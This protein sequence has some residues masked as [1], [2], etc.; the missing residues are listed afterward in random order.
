M[1]CL[2]AYSVSAYRQLAIQQETVRQKQ[3]KLSIVVALAT[4]TGLI[5][6]LM[7]SAPVFVFV[8]AAN[9]DG[10]SGDDTLNGT[11]EADT[12]NGFDGNDKLFGEAGDDT[13][14]GGN[15]DDEIGGGPG[16]D[17]I[18]DAN[19]EVINYG[20]KVYGGS[21]DDNIDLGIDYTLSD[22]YAVYGEDG[23]DY[24]KVVSNAEIHGGPDD[25]TIY[26][27]GYECGIAG[28]EG[29]DEIHVELHDVGSGVSGGSGNDKIFGK[30]YDV[31]GGGGNDYLSLDYAPYIEG[32]EGND[33]LEVL[34]PSSDSTIMVGRV[35]TLSIAHLVLVTG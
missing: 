2:I 3:K 31:N 25:D 22:W 21:G 14:D 10:T 15:G 29:D 33:V 1:E 11:D 19:E 13:L 8:F 7:P 30:G 23:S 32:D 27:T 35:P 28:D 16:N 20:N 12:I 6:L 24:I 34:E 17:E 9:I 4:F 5:V 26:C 18:K